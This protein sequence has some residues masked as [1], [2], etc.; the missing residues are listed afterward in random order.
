MS[1]I[2]LP[3]GPSPARLSR[4]MGKMA[5]A[6]VLVSALAGSAASAKEPVT[7]VLDQ[8]KVMK[9]DKPAATVIV[10]NPAIADAVMHDRTTLVIV[11]RGFGSTNLIVLGE[12]GQPIADETLVVQPPQNAL[13]T[14]QRR[15][16]RYS[17]S[18]APICAP[19][20]N[21]GDDDTFFKGSM[22]QVAGRNSA[23]QAAAGGKSN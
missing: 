17:Y 23:A 7:V 18:C 12:D 1:R 9:I 4:A 19:T 21:P 13:V 3:A 22:D 15:G 14:V 16:A 6:L 10:G 11:G 2:V 5:A 20:V 8:A